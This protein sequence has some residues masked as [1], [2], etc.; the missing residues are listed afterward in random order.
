MTAQC[1]CCQVDGVRG[2]TASLASF[3]EGVD[4]YNAVVSLHSLD[5]SILNLTSEAISRRLVSWGFLHREPCPADLESV[6]D[7]V[8][9][10]ES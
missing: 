6:I 4:V 2:A 8:R 9:Q 10:V 3:T 7:L 1:K 5:R